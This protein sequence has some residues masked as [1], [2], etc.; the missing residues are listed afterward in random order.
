[1]GD[2]MNSTLWTMIGIGATASLIP[3]LRAIIKAI[4]AKKSTS[5]IVA[6][7]LEAA[8]DGVDKRKK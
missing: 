4:R 5:D 3:A 7:A 8:V 2:S 6:D 1:M